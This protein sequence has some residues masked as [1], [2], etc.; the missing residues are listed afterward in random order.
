MPNQE[1]AERHDS[2]TLDTL[3]EAMVESI[4]RWTVG[5]TDCLT[6]ISSLNL[7]RRE[8]PM[9]PS[10]CLVEASVVLVVQGE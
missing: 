3:R 10:T 9:P 7:F 5:K 6:A 8:R 4:G 2:G 1:R